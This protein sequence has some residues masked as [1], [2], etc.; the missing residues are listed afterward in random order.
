MQ[1]IKSRDYKKL[2][3]FWELHLPCQQTPGM[4]LTDG[5]NKVF[6]AGGLPL[7]SKNWYGWV[8]YWGCFHERATITQL[9]VWLV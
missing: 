8:D 1:E 9:T 2:H 4:C 6:L 7:G 5:T 3:H